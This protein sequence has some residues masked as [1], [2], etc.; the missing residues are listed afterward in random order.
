VKRALLPPAEWIHGGERYLPHS[1]AAKIFEHLKCHGQKHPLIGRQQFEKC[2]VTVPVGFSGLQR[3][4]I[5]LAMES[6]QLVLEAFVHEPFA[7]MISHFY[8]PHTKL[9]KLRG[10]RVLVFD[11]GGGTLD[12]CVAEGSTDGSALYELAHDGIADHAG[13]DFDRRIMADMRGRF[14]K[15]HPEITNDDIDVRCRAA[16]RFWMESERAKINLSSEK[17]T[18]VRVPRFLEGNDPIDLGADLTRKEFEA[19]IENEVDRAVA[20][21]LRC[22]AAARLTPSSIDY[23]IMVGGTS[24]IPLVRDR[25][26]E[27]FGTK[28]QVTK[29][30]D[31]AIARGAAIV[32]AEEWKPVNA[33]TLGCEL[34]RGE[35]YTFLKRGEPLVATNSKKS[36]FYCTDPR[37]GSA[38]FVFARKPNDDSS[39]VIPTGELLQVPVQHEF[40]KEFRELDRLIVR[41]SVTKDATLLIDVTHSGTGKTA[42]HEIADVSFGLHLKRT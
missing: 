13:D 34:A 36:V 16:D 30:P 27:R 32:A 42:E 10:R 15:A 12:I 38:T 22:V 2:V 39:E 19:L 5:R 9:E 1:I 26:Q 20:C 6:C 25:L 21:A 23:V 29:E 8:D 4:Q 40:P 37:H 18:R 7:A 24:L 14:L 33:V 35:F 28:V 31:A 17:E 3:R 11:W 41:S